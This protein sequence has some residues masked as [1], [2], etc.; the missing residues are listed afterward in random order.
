MN[1][2][3]NCQTQFNNK[4]HIQPD[5]NQEENQKN[6]KRELTKK[7]KEKNI[8]EIKNMNMIH[9][10]YLTI[11]GQEEVEEVC[12]CWVIKVLI[13]GKKFISGQIK[14]VLWSSVELISQQC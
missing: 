1:I 2:G 14:Q 12:K 6:L 11:V 9:L 3:T 13:E 10:I 8:E 7:C 4:N 5:R